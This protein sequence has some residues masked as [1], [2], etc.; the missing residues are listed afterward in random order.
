[1]AK[2]QLL[3]R[4]KT[5]TNVESLMAALARATDDSL[6]A[7][8]D[9]CELPDELALLAVGGYGRGELAPHSDIDILVLLPDAPVEHLRSAHRTLYQPRVGSGAGTRQQ[10]AQRVAMSRRSR[11]RRHRAHLAARSAA[12]HGQRGA[13]R[14]LR[15]ALPRGA[16]PAGILPGESAGNAPAPR[17]VPGH[18]LRARTQ[19]Q[20]KPGRPARSAADSVDHPGG[21]FRQQLARTRSARPDHRARSARTAPQRRLPEDAARAAARDRRASPGHPGV[22]PADAGGRE[23]RLQ[24]DR[25]PSAPA[26]S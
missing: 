15:E 5:A 18:A 7:A 19:H 2:A 24:A 11:Q 12:H 9:T 8:W 1:M 13:V 14:R 6:R 21:R 3:E 16:R 20:G 23:L 22:R 4:F 10:R 25:R 26:N 17:Q